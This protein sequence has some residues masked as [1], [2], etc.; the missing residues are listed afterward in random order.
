MRTF[1]FSAAA[2]SI[3]TTGMLLATTTS[4]LAFAPCAPFTPRFSF[5]QPMTSEAFET[6]SSGVNV[7]DIP[8]IIENLT[9]EN[10]DE[11]L[12]VL[13]PLLMNECVGEVCMDYIG[14]VEAKAEKMGKAIPDSYAPKLR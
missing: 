8:S 7:D 13:E 6:A 12:E 10:F 5:G 1:T 4:T 2:A 14:D 9:A 11:S 3:A